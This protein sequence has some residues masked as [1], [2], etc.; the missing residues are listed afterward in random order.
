MK[1]LNNIEIWVNRC[2]G[3]SIIVDLKTVV[4]E[5]EKNITL[6]VGDVISFERKFTIKDV[7]LFTKV[8]GDEGDQHINLDEQGRAYSFGTFSRNHYE[9]NDFPSW[10][11][12]LLN[13]FCPSSLA[14]ICLL[15]H[16]Y[17]FGSRRCLKYSSH[18]YGN[19]LV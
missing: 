5:E 19:K 16:F 4:V 18:S 13:F 8:S 10:N 15:Q 12:Y 17:L 9:L 2:F 6:Q 11:Q 14:I 1:L 7:K 3:V